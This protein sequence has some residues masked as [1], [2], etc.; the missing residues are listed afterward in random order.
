MWG[1]AWRTFWSVVPGYLRAM[2]ERQAGSPVSRGV[3]G[4]IF[5]TIFLDLLGVG[6]IIPILPILFFEADSGFFGAEVSMAQRS[7]LYGFLIAA[8]PLLQ[9]FGAPLLG[10]LSDRHGRRPVL[11]LALG[12]SLLGYLLFAYALEMRILWL[13][14]VARMIPGFT[15]GNIAVIYSSLADVSSSAAER[16]RYFGLVGVA[17][18]LGFVLGPT[19][20]GILADDKV[21]S[22]FTP[23]VPLVFVSLLTL[24]NLLLVWWRFPETLREPRESKLDILSGFRNIGTA[25]ES[26]QL[27]DVFVV[28]LLLSLGFTF[29]TQFFSVYLISRFGWTELQVGLLFGW[30]GIWLALTQGVLV[31][32]LSTRVTPRKVLSWSLPFVALTIGMLLIPEQA[33]GFFIVN[34]LVAVFFG[35]TS[36]N[37]TSVVSEQASAQEQGEILGINQ[38]MQSLGQFVPPI[39]AGFLTALNP[40]YPLVA[41]SIL[42]VLAWLIFMLSVGRR[43]GVVVG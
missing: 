21:V 17:F 8:Y 27:R 15:G 1:Y 3:L 28:V 39:I 23:T 42:I 36:P 4:T 24:L 16:T 41:S 7:I 37:L 10:S 18:G 40:S 30:V 14:F 6:L 9:F 32:W 43:K 2:D 38:S 26:A 31:R 20:G 35:L 11:M 19:L 34:A 25:F 5:L 13:L 22:W 29:F 12:G 33:W